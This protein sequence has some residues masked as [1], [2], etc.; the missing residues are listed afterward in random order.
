MMMGLMMRRDMKWLRDG[1]IVF[2]KK[3]CTGVE[4]W[5]E[6]LMGKGNGRNAGRNERTEWLKGGKGRSSINM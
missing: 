6:G 3:S 4:G 5:E 1:S 2:T